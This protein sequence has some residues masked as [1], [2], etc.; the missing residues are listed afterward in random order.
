MDKYASE[1]LELSKYAP[2]AATTE[3]IKVKRFLKGLDRR[4]ANL[5]ILSDQPL[6]V[7]VDRAQQVKISYMGMMEAER[8]RIKSKGHQVC[9]I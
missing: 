6:D 4:Y 1:F 9:H 3:S 2:I 8:R 7:V 5:A